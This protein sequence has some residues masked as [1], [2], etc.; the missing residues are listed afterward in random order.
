MLKNQ[1][2]IMA[3]KWR[4]RNIKFPTSD[5]LRPTA[6]RTR[7]TLFNWLAPVINHI[8]CLELFAGSG[9]LGFESLSRGA[10][11]VVMIDTS[12]EAVQQLKETAKTLNAENLTIHQMTAEQYIQTSKEKFDLVFIDPPFSSNLVE[13]ICHLLDKQDLLNPNAYIYIETQKKL[14]PPT[15]PASWQILKAKIAGQ[16]A[17]YLIKKNT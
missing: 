2:K 5:G 3:G 16:V 6:N 7:E 10:G 1:V 4:G 14:S 12:T 13:P 9:S 17:Y 11:H 8:N 15:V